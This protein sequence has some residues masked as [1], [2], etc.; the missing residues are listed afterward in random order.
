LEPAAVPDPAPALTAPA[1]PARRAAAHAAHLA[2]ASV[3]LAACAKGRHVI[4]A[5][6]SEGVMEP[7]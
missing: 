1:P 7:V 2:A 6:V 3:P 5:A 4:P